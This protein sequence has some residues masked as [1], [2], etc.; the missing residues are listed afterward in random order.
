MVASALVGGL[1]GLAGVAGVSEAGAAEHASRATSSTTTTTTS[2]AP[3]VAAEAEAAL[4]TLAAFPSGWLTPSA[5]AAPSH[6]SALSKQLASCLGASEKIAQLKPE[7]YNSPSFTNAA[8]SLA[9]EESVAIYASSAQAQSV[10]AALAVHKLPTC[11][12][13][14]DSGTLRSA[15]QQQA[16]TAPPWAR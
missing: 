8:K 5:A 1:A 6:V 9:V 11:I 3:A 12:S 13:S 2:V 7:T 15:I 16:G 10:H 4:L 14:L